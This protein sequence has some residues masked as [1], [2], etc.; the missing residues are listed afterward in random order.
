MENNTDLMEQFSRATILLHRYQHH[1][2][3]EQGPFADPHRGQGRILAL[4]KMQ[5]EISQKDLSYLLDM[6]NQSLS[7]LLTKLEKAGFITR[8]QS[9]TDRRVMD[10]RLTKEGEEAANQAEEGKQDSGQIFD[11]LDE[12]ERK[13]LSEYLARIITE[14][15]KQMGGKI[16]FPDAWGPRGTMP[17]MIQHLRESG[18][19]FDGFDRRGFFG[20]RPVTPPPPAPPKGHGN[21]RRQ[22]D[23]D[24]E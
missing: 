12:V 14:L 17:E 16:D 18:Y 10:I 24:D 21:G 13:N 11:C 3:K 20:G 19:P 7:E 22:D 4:L 15:E 1:S 5:P 6:R 9:E 8:T 23:S 2:R